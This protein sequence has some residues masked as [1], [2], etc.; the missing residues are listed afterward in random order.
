MGGI[1]RTGEGFEGN[2]DSP[3]L[4]KTDGEGVG[5]DSCLDVRSQIAAP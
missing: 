4:A 3:L 5:E 2:E 1:V